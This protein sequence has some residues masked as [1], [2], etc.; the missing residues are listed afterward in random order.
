ME[1]VK[2][3]SGKSLAQREGRIGGL[4]LFLLCSALEPPC[5]VLLEAYKGKKQLR[6]MS[7]LGY[8]DTVMSGSV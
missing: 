8:V 3:Q 6:G 1:E 4:G 2:N 7:C 5:T